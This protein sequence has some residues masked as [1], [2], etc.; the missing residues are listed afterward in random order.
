MM[1]LGFYSMARSPA[2]NQFMI[3]T[4][5]PE[6]RIKS[7]GDLLNAQETNREQREEDGESGAGSGVVGR[8]ALKS[9]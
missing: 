2:L 6:A 9:A 4:D 8:A 1:G 5:G 3:I 7:R